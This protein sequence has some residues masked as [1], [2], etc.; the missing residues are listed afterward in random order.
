MA[1]L[2]VTELNRVIVGGANIVVPVGAVP[3]PAEQA[4]AIG[5]GSTQSAAFNADTRF[6][7]V[8]AD[9]ACCLAFGPNPTAVTTAHRLPAGET[10]YYGVAPGSKVAAI[11]SS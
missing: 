5:A 9:T 3:G 10:R 7:M 11:A 8:S 2:F 1:T 4:V 6:I